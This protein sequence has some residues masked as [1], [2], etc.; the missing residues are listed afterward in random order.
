MKPFPA[1][2]IPCNL[3]MGRYL[4]DARAPHLVLVIAGRKEAK[5]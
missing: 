2:A 5:Q 3:V 1:T 4:V